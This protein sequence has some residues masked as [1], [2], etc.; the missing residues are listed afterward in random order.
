MAARLVLVHSPLVG[1]TTWDLAAADLTRR[2]Y[3]VAVPDLALRL[4]ASRTG[5]AR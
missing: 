1:C 5:P 2:G 3:D 4:R